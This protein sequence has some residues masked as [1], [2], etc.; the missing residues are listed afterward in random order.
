MR[1][2]VNFKIGFSL[3]D[4]CKKRFK[5]KSYLNQHVHHVHTSER[6][7]QCDACKKRFKSKW[8]LNLHVHRLHTS[9]TQVVYD[10]AIAEKDN[11]IVMVSHE[12]LRPIHNDEEDD[13]LLHLVTLELP[14][15]Y[16]GEVFRG[17][18]CRDNN[19]NTKQSEVKRRSKSCKY[20]YKMFRSTSSVIIRERVQPRE[21]SYKS[22]EVSG[23]IN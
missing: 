22:G 21:T 10:A 2:L 14:D 17:V 1:K 11:D 20:C 18:I 12:E 5:C 4:T 19:P 23:N 16:Y 8:N 7:F 3:C 6:G 9:G 13:F 15:F